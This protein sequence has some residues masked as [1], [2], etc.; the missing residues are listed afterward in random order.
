MGNDQLKELLD[1]LEK[2]E[3][4]KLLDV[5][6][7]KRGQTN[8]TVKAFIKQ[9]NIRAGLKR[10]PNY[11]VFFY[12]INK[13]NAA[14]SDKLN[15]YSFF[16][17]F[18]KFFPKARIGSQRYYLL[19]EGS[20]DLSRESKR[21]AKVFD[22]NYRIRSIAYRKSRKKNKNEKSKESQEKENPSE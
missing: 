15:K 5:N 12:Y 9:F 19:D 11:L 10:V 17:E 18:S 2:T 20:F 21:E 14:R 4:K 13:L 7:V 6:E 1:L 8:Y 3:E 22:A 16:R